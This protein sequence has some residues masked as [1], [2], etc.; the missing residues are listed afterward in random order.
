MNYQS[1]NN[2]GLFPSEEIRLQVTPRTRDQLSRLFGISP[3][4]FA[5]KMG[6]MLERCYFQESDDGNSLYVYDP[7]R[8]VMEL[9]SSDMDD[10]YRVVAVAPSRNIKKDER[11][12]P[13]EAKHVGVGFLPAVA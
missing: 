5:R 13:Q 2:L 4:K 8:V 11:R 10:V 9:D 1:N 12:I 3:Y 7:I 6:S